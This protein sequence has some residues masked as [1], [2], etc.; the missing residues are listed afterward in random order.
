[1]N[2]KLR[3][4]N[5]TPSMSLNHI[6]IILFWCF[7]IASNA[8]ANGQKQSALSS[9]SGAPIKSSDFAKLM[10][11]LLSKDGQSNVLD[12]KFIF[13]QC[14]GG[15]FLD[16]LDKAFAATGIKWV[17]GT[18]TSSD[19]F[20]YGQ[21]S[22]DEVKGKSNLTP[23]EQAMISDKVPLD[24]WTKALLPE[25]AKDQTVLDAINKAKD[26]DKLGTGNGADPKLLEILRKVIGKNAQ[27][28]SGQSKTGNGGENIT[29]KNAS[30]ESH[31]AIVWDGIV[32]RT[33][34]SNDARSIID[35]LKQTWGDPKNNPK[36]KIFEV[37]N[38]NDLTKAITEIQKTIG[39]NEEFLFYA[40]DHGQR[41]SMLQ[42]KPKSVEPHTVDIESFDLSQGEL[43]GMLA[44]P[45]N[46]PLVTVEY[47]SIS[48]PLKVLLNDYELGY[49]DPNFAYM[50][51][52]V[53]EDILGL[54]N[55][56]QIYNTMD[57]LFTLNAKSFLTGDISSMLPA[58]VSEPSTL[59]LFFIT[60]LALLINSRISSLRRAD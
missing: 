5:A 57:F 19:N 42:D 47:G 60:F 29:L 50:D 12:A 36:V 1:M 48:T 27:P 46:T 13:Q 58:I 45:D 44:T 28:E 32:T 41:L 2:S 18:A 17:G 38:K 9:N 30:A 31:Y 37:Y 21:D 59:Q 4:I 43:G 25:L 54:T 56:V 22:P 3:N 49:L 20:A 11:D 52:P 26:A 23:E 24:Y 51:F 10:N 8:S 16:E 34:H 53:P 6:L 33:R 7:L 14:Y 39:V 15:G 35:T 40:T 55:S